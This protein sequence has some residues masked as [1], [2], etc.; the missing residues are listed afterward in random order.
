MDNYSGTES[1]IGAYL[2]TPGPESRIEFFV[3]TLAPVENHESQ[4]HLVDTLTELRANEQLGDVCVTVWGSRICTEG[5]IASLD[6]GKHIVETIGDFF[7]FAA[8]EGVNISLHF[9]IKDVD[10]SMTGQSF[11]SIVPPSQCTAMY[12]ADEL[13]GVFPCMIDDECYTVRDAVEALEARADQSTE[14][15]AETPPTE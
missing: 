15:V 7:A 12:E 6:S 11:K 10:S 4:G 9:R 13:V 3:Q 8:D 2:P 14:Y 5:P 1:P